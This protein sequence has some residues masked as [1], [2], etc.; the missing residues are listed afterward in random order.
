MQQLTFK[1]LFFAG[2]CSIGNIISAQ[3][4]VVYTTAKDT[5]LRITKTATLPLDKTTPPVN[6]QLCVYVDD[7]HQFQDFFGIGSALTDASAETFAKMPKAV[8]NELLTAFYDKEKGIGYSLARTHINSCDFSS[9]S[10]TYVADNDSLLKTF[11]IAHDKKFRIPFIQKAIAAA[12][13]T[14]PL[15][16]SPWTP[17]AWMKDNNSMLKGGSLL[18]QY[19]QTWADY[20]VKF[21][22]AYQAE[23]IPIFGMTVQNEPMAAQRWESCV[24]NAQQEADFVKNYLGPTLRKNELPDK[25]IIIWDYNR[26]A[27]AQ[28]AAQIL[29]DRDV[30][31]YVWAV[32]YH[33]YEAWT[34]DEMKFDNV[35]AVRE[36]FPDKHVFLTEACIVKYSHD[37][38][39]E[40]GLGEKYGHSMVNDFNS[41]AIAWTDWNI[42]LDEK[43]GPNHVGNVCFAPVI[44]DTKTGEVHYTSIY[45]YIGHFS[46]FIRPGAKRI[47]SA[48][49]KA[50]LEVTA[51]QN[52]DGKNV[53]VVMNVSD[54]EIEYSL[55][56][57]NKSTV[58]TALPHSIS[59]IVISSEDGNAPTL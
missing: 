29:N 38:I 49:N 3:Q 48:S 50:G 57:K 42:I 36:A 34:I 43:G 7:S 27:L 24:F 31:Q 54:S 13:G 55:Y 26:H 8:Q 23:N 51:F 12:G 41:G 58:I 28:S 32:G 52:P 33:W 16:V 47:M 40:W 53:A 45:Y 5:E 59:T 25:K 10:Y 20:F 39:Y 44:A 2:I 4:A 6:K 19:Y 17:P 37:R 22:R 14:L 46:K 21:I 30:A 35:R 11:N 15:F 56:C 18:P 9:K 1:I